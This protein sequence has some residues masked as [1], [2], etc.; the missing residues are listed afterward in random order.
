MQRDASLGADAR[1]NLKI[2]GRSGEHLL[3]LINDV[4]DMSKIEAGRTEL[5]PN[6][7][8]LVGLIDDL[9]AMFRLRAEAKALRFEMSVDVKSLQYIIGDEGKVRQVLINLLG[10]AIKFTRQ[11]EVGMHVAVEQRAPDGL[12]L[13][14]R[15]R[16]TGVGIRSEEQVRLFEPFSQ[17]QRTVNV[18]E[19]TGLGLAISRKYARLMGGDVTVSST[20]GQGS[21]FGFE[22]PVVRGDSGVAVRPFAHKR[23]VGLAVTQDAPRIL[24]VDDQHANRDW[25]MKLLSA[26]A[27]GGTRPPGEDFGRCGR[28]PLGA[29]AVDFASLSV[30]ITRRSHRGPMAHRSIGN[31]GCLAI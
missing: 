28:H 21:V 26:R 12:W 8:N 29:R 30:A 27:T 22:I 6:T 14:V 16:D 18:L 23:V 31:P 7:F 15:V 4:L 9:A 1:S 24:V 2:I 11:G 13:T 3:G 20:P 19:G 10:N 25:L 5:N 17:A